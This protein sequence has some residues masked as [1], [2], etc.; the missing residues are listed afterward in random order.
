MR[1][2]LQFCNYVIN[3]NFRVLAVLFTI[4]DPLYLFAIFNLS[5]DATFKL[6]TATLHKLG[7]RIALVDT[8]LHQVMFW[9]TG[10]IPWTY[11]FTSFLKLLKSYIAK[12]TPDIVTCVIFRSNANSSLKIY[13][14]RISYFK[15]A[16]RCSAEE[17]L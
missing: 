6:F 10:L 14:T 5:E 3:C 15:V 9:V 11:R 7:E 12:Y 4:T 13:I 1:Y 8:V 2:I 16:D 17:Q